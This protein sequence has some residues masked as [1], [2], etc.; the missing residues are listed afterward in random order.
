MSGVIRHGA[1]PWLAGAVMGAAAA[2][3]L[4]AACAAWG[5]PPPSPLERDLSRL[6]RRGGVAVGGPGGPAFIYGRGRFIPASIIKLATALA[7]FHYLGADYRFKTEFY[8]DSRR[9]LIVRGLGDPIMVSEEW[10]AIA[11]ELAAQGVFAR[12]LG[13]LVLDESAFSADVEVDGATNSD[14][15]YDA[16]LGALVTNFNTIFVRVAP[17]AQVESAEEQTPLTPL[18]VRLARGLP[19]GE[20]RINLSQEPRNSLRYTG[21]LAEVFLRRAGA[22]FEGT[23]TEGKTPAGLKPAWVHRS[24]HPLREVVRRMMEFSNNYIA[25]Q[26]VMTMGREMRGGPAGLAK[27]MALVSEYLR[28]RIGLPADAF[29]LVEGS[30]LSPRNRITLAAMLR[31]VEAFRPWRD[32]LR[33]YGRPPRRALAKTGTLTGVYTLAGFLPGEG[34]RPLPFV[35]M[36]NQPRNTRGKVFARLARH[37]AAAPSALGAKKRAGAGR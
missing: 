2:L 27:G 30:G 35:I 12:P 4:L 11:D 37:F 22:R 28:E 32:L 17:N 21:E 13:N 3:V 7:A 9:N 19:P 34:G 14:N 31:I 24:A 18:A 8:L 25:N 26:V 33:T 20:H 10:A 6:V 15:P 1:R 29:S 5:A 16:R 23:I 36:L